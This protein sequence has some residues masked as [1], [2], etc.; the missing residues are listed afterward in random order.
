MFLA[1]RK[2]VF[3][4]SEVVR[5]NSLFQAGSVSHEEKLFLTRRKCVS[6]KDPLNIVR[7]KLCFL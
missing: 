7:R 3:C 2:R 5:R 4:E 1:R 6:G